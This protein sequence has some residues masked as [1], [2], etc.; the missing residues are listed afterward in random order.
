MHHSSRAVGGAVRCPVMEICGNELWRSATRCERNG[1]G[2]CAGNVTGQ[3]R[4]FSHEGYRKCFGQD[5]QSIR[6]L[7]LGSA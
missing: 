2:R 3:S 7:E 6:H 5:G 4:R 1:K